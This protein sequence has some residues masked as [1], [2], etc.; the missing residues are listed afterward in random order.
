MTG[1]KITK[2]NRSQ[3]Q[4]NNTLSVFK[5]M[6]MCNNVLISDKSQQIFDKLSDVTNM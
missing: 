1:D 3:T 5:L 6:V 4:M 2:V